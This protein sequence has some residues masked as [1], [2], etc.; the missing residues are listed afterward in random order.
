M[1]RFFTVILC[2]LALLPTMADT[3]SR[4]RV[5]SIGNSFARDAFAY[6]PF[7]IEELS[8]GTKVDFSILYIGGCSLERHYNGLVGI[9]RKM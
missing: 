5:L 1:K 9:W 6:V 2:A 8:P 3:P 7:L 4:V